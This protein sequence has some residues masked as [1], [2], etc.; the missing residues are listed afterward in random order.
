MQNEYGKKLKEW[1]ENE[2]LTPT[3]LGKRTGISRQNITRWENEGILPNIDFC[4][5]L[6]NYY[7]ITIDDLIGRTEQ[8]PNLNFTSTVTINQAN[9]IHAPN[10]SIIINQNN[11]DK[12]E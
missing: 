5:K 8:K 1:R 10:S 6:A 11:G 7:G 9:N 3:E 2:G 12:N 4:V